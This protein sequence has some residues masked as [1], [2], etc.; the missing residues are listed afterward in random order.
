MHYLVRFYNIVWRL[1][2]SPEDLTAYDQ[3]PKEVVLDL[4]IEPEY[5]NQFDAKMAISF[6]EMYNWCGVES[7]DVE[8]VD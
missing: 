4:F 5:K 2:E 3:L 1:P 7:V 8:W 6:L